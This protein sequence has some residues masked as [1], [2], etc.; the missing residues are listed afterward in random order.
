MGCP[1]SVASEA[2]LNRFVVEGV[3][4]ATCVKVIEEEGQYRVVAVRRFEVGDLVM[5]IQG[6][7]VATASRYTLQ[8]DGDHHVAVPEHLSS[9]EII[10]QYPWRFLNHSCEA[11]TMVHDSEVYAIKPIDAGEEVTFNYN[12]TELEIVHSFECTCGS[13]SCQRVIRGFRFLSHE[14]QRLLARVLAPHL[15][16]LLANEPQQVVNGT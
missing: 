6:E 3:V 4:L 13:I 8:V 16:R 9:Q 14:H 15:S 7:R 11:N 10:E 12:T 1:A 5:G 2:I